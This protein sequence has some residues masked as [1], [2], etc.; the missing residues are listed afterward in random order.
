MLYIQQGAEGGLRVQ[1]A[2]DSDLGIILF[3]LNQ[4]I[5]DSPTKTAVWKHS[6]TT[7]SEDP[8]KALHDFIT[9]SDF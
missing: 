8:L 1:R 9:T 2:T 5:Y 7:P 6:Q 4:N 3:Q